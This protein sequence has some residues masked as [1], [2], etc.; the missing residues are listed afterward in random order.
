MLITPWLTSIPSPAVGE[1]RRAMN[2]FASWQTLQVWYAYLQVE[3]VQAELRRNVDPNTARR[4]EK[5]F[6]KA[7]TRGHLKAL[8]KLV[9]VVDGDLR[10]ISNPPFVVPIDELVNSTDADAIMAKVRSAL[11]SYHNSLSQE[12]RRL[13]EQFGLVHMARKV[14]G[15]GSAAPGHGFCCCSVETSAIR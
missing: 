10:F 1:Y 9:R 3:R 4:A 11:R 7:K 15:V 13:L 12:R 14:V 6:A 5:A 8:A 2:E